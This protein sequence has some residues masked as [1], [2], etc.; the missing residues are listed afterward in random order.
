MFSNPSSFRSTFDLN[1]SSAVTNQNYKCA[2][3]RL[4]NAGTNVIMRRQK[5]PDQL[6]AGGGATTPTNDDDRP[7]RR[8]S[9]L[10]ATANDSSLQLLDGD[11]TTNVASLEGGSP[12]TTESG[13][14]AEAARSPDGS[15][16]QLTVAQQLKR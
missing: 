7:M 8:V 6:E 5:I 2:C 10:R 4:S 12:T 16:D 15:N 9:Y 14:G 3:V 11:A 1:V 13:G